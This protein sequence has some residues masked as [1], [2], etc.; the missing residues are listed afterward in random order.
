MTDPQ[1]DAVI[2]V[3]YVYYSSYSDWWMQQRQQMK[4]CVL[5]KKMCIRAINELNRQWNEGIV[6]AVQSSALTNL[7]KHYCLNHLGKDQQ[8]SLLVSPKCNRRLQDPVSMSA[9][10]DASGLQKGDFM[11]SGWGGCYRSCAVISAAHQRLAGWLAAGHTAVGL[12]WTGE[13]GEPAEKTLR[14]KVV[15]LDA[16]VCSLS[17]CVCLCTC[18]WVH[19]SQSLC[20]W[21]TVC[22]CVRVSV[23]VCVCPLNDA[24]CESAWLLHVYSCVWQLLMF[25]RCIMHD[26]KTICKAALALI[27]PDC[28]FCLGHPD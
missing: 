25:A 20:V 8:R 24:A 16:S 21:V 11:V 17:V 4:E 7:H 3:H 5:E 6:L 27:W 26:K 2:N 9:P 10:V 15:H 22:L 13:H 12:L 18:G 1:T 28:R 19:L 14:Y 23:C